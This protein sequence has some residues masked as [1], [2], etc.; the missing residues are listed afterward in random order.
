[1]VVWSDK[2]RRSL[3][4]APLI[5][6]IAVLGG[7]ASSES[8]APAVTPAI[9]AAA[10][11]SAEVL[12]EGRVIYTTRCTDCHNAVAVAAHTRAEWP[13]IIRRMAPESDLTPQQEQAVRA[14]VMAFAR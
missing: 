9:A 14:Y 13:G 7:C 3:V 2:G 6:A 11:T 5:C 4:W 12:N 8:T 1:M 10:R